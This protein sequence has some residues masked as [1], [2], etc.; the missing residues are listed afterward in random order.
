MATFNVTPGKGEVGAE[1]GAVALLLNWRMVRTPCP[2]GQ[3]SRLRR[4]ALQRVG[5]N[6]DAK[7][8]GHLLPVSV[9]PVTYF[10]CENLDDRA[11]PQA[12]YIY[13]CIAK[14]SGDA[15]AAN[16]ADN[17]PHP[18]CVLTVAK[19]PLTENL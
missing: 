2:E 8:T 3:A 1:P 7:S 4:V 10:R 15:I 18:F 14:F 16:L 17:D 12:S 9:N 19:F 11:L 13:R 5:Q 6:L